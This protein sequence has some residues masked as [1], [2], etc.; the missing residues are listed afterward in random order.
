MMQSLGRQYVRYFNHSYKRSGT[1][2]EGRYKSCLVQEED[3]LMRLYRY[4]ELNPV[5]A[6]MVKDP[7]EYKWSSYGINALGEQTEFCKPH[8]LY[9]SLGEDEQG[10]QQAYRELFKHEIDGKMI[11]EIRQMTQQGM[12]LGNERFKREIEKLTGRRMSRLK[13][14][15]PITEKNGC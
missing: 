9:L 12:A 4:I 13:M 14:G 7:A 8:S 5:R 1:L 10:R 2:W 6:G 3:Y 15:R 11:K